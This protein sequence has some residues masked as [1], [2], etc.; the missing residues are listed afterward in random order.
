MNIDTILESQRKFFL[1]GATLPVSFRV[2]MLKKLYAAV[3]NT[4]MRL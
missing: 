1:T 2:E 3:K 4:K